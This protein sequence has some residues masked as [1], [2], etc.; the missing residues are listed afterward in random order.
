[1]ILLFSGGIDSL[2]AYHYLGKPQTLYFHLNTKYSA[3]ELMVVKKLIPSTIVETCID[4]KSREV[5]GSAFVPYRNLHL[6]LMAAHYSSDIAI[7][8]VRDDKVSDKSEEAFLK[9]SSIMT[10]LSDRAITV[11]SP[12]WHL[13]KAEVVKWFLDN[14]GTK[15]ELLSTISC[16]SDTTEKECHA[17]KACFRKWCALRENGIYDFEFNNDPLLWEYFDKAMGGHYEPKRNAS[18]IKQITRIKP[19]WYKL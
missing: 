4:F 9:F 5:E 8:G 10:Y 16:Y 11:F 15:E 18:I 14:G 3:K 19:H 12:F 6:A 13:T 2:I 17:C 1:M 7:A